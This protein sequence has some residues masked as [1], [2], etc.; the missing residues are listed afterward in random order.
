MQVKIMQIQAKKKRLQVKIMQ[1]QAKNTEMP[2]RDPFGVSQNNA[3]ASEKE[4][5]AGSKNLIAG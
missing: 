5:I 2:R 3:N 4:A 1:M